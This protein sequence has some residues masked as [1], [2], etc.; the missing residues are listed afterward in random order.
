MSAVPSEIGKSDAAPRVVPCRFVRLHLAEHCTGYTVKA[1]ERKIE[2]GEW[3]EGREY[4]RA[5]DGHI[6]IDLLGYEKWA[7]K[8]K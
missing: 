4:R 5:P 8:G 2:R 1:M 7:S 3:A 6:L